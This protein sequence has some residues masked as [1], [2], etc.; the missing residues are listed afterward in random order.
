MN[1]DS[2]SFCANK[3]YFRREKPHNF[4]NKHILSKKLNWEVQFP[5]RRLPASRRVPVENALFAFLAGMRKV[6]YNIKVEGFTFP[7]SHL[8]VKSM[9]SCYIMVSLL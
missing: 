6:H 3:M 1:Q 2:F 9:H 8:F 7:S 4:N 5:Q